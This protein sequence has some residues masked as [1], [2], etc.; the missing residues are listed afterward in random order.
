MTT[1]AA[2]ILVVDDEDTIRTIITDA[3][4]QHGYNVQDAAT[5]DQ[6]LR[7]CETTPFDLVLLDL[8]IPGA[9]DGLDLLKVIRRRWSQTVVIMLTGYGSLD[10]AI[11]ALRAG[12]F[13]YLTKPVSTTQIVESVERGLEKHREEL[14]RQQLVTHLEAT[15]QALKTA[16]LLST[17]P[18]DQRFTHTATLTIDRH[19][20]LVVRGDEL[21]ELTATE[22]DILDYLARAADRI[23]TASELVKA[24]QG[25]ELMEQDARPMIRVHIQRLR[26]KLGDDPE[27]PRYILNVRGKGY[28][29]IG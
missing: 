15:L 5:S 28:R 20:R 12:A 6:A 13:D 29:F 22:F 17:P 1:Q 27:H 21:I 3:L 14:R 8:K 19:K 2:S 23:V 7:L 16:N 9:M 11:N 24:T 10:S 4:T 18:L 26:Q 25:Y